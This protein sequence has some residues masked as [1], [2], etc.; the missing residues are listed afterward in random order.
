MKVA[1]ILTTALGIYLLVHLVLKIGPAVLA[2]QLATLGWSLA[3]LAVLGLVKLGLRTWSWRET[4]VADGVQA[5]GWQLFGARLISQTF[6]Y[7]SAAGPLVADPLKPL[8]LRDTDVAASTPG[9]LV[10]TV[11]FWF[12][13]LLIILAGGF[14]G[15]LVASSK[16]Q[17]LFVTLALVAMI[18]AG[19][20]LLL[21]KA[22]LVPRLRGVLARKW[23]NHPARLSAWLIKAERIEE[24]T[25][26]FHLRH[27][28]ALRH[29]VLLNLAVQIVMV[30][31]VLIVVAAIGVKIGFLQ[32]LAT[33][34]ANRIA[35]V[36][37]FYIPARV[38]ADEASGAG[39]FVLFG[40]D[41]A[42][43]LTLAIARR[44]Q[45]LIWVAVGLAWWH[46]LGSQKLKNGGS[47]AISTVAVPN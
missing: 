33:E 31:E 17:L 20:L 43:G 36:L 34:G 24:P 7:L 15:I 19:F 45:A 39:S 2:T 22:P 8:L 21:K 3:I 13:S 11:V 38:G 26:S 14:A 28:K 9:T 41:G 1:T 6:G 5:S 35:K 37:T 30:A 46:V 16:P 10:E 27:P 44:I 23:K 18:M 29:A 42:A 4:L 25:I 47:C 12:T 40:M 32:L